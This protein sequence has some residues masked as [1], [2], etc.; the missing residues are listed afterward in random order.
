MFS[1]VRTQHEK[2]LA[3]DASVKCPSAEAPA[4][5]NNTTAA[6][7]LVA[8]APGNG[9][10]AAK[11]GRPKKLKRPANLLKS[12]ISKGDLA[13]VN[14]LLDLGVNVNVRGR[15]GYNP[16]YWAVGRKDSVDF[17]KT[18]LDRGAN[19]NITVGNRL[20]E[21]KTTP[22]L[23]AADWGDY[24]AL[25]LLLDR[26]ADLHARD[27]RGCTALH[28]APTCEG[29]FHNKATVSARILN[30]LLDKGLD[31]NALDS[32]GHTPVLKA[33][34][35]GSAK[36]ID[37]LMQRGAN[38]EIPDRWGIT[39]LCTVVDFHRKDECMV[40]SLLANGVNPNQPD[41]FGNTPLH[42]AAKNDCWKIASILLANG[43]RA[44]IPNASGKT[45]LDIAIA[46][47]AVVTIEVLNY[48]LTEHQPATLMACARTCIRSRLIENRVLAKA[49]A[50]DSDCLPLPHL[51][52][53][54]LYQPLGGCPR[55]A[56]DWASP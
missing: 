15:D 14:R 30:Y 10:L 24:P 25:K 37:T 56:P 17:I 46:R 20:L 1:N 26:G 21:E 38:P 42:L 48:Y 3:A 11:T 47:G 51:I 53:K 33:V 6:K 22:F 16:L 23:K 52:K 41:K 31:I 5:A 9:Q 54:Y 36:A 7:Q 28:L 55:I 49:L 27:D 13:S 34:T 43:A 12:A 35:N 8:S 2:E 18:L 44:D 45:A 29:L 4:S 50:P 39:P 40:N 32:S 19:P